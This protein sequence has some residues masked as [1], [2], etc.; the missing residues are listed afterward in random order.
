MNIRIHSSIAAA[1]VVAVL[2]LSAPAPAKANTFSTLLIGAAAAG[3]A[4]TAIN[5]T[6]KNNK[7]RALAGYLPNGDAVYQDGHVATRSGGKYYPGDHG[8]TL[9]CENQRCRIVGTNGNYNGHHYR[10]THNGG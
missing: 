2:G 1:L 8:Q 6:N 9:Q 4:L 7:A 3:A 10:M 5:V